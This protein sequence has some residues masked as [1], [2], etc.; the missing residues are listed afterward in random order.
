MRRA[1]SYA[2]FSDKQQGDGCSEERQVDAAKAYCERHGLTLDERSFVDRGVSAYTGANATKGELAE[3]LHLVREGRVP[4]GSAL[5]IENVD[6][7]SRLD[8][9]EATELFC[10]IVKAGVDIVTLAPEQWYKRDN[11]HRLDIW[12]P[13]QVAIALAREESRKKSERIRDA[14]ARKRGQL[15]DDKGKATGVRFTKR[16]PFWLEYDGDGGWTVIPEKAE[17]MVTMFEWAAA[18]LGMTKISARAYEAWPEGITGK[19]WQPNNIR[20]HLRSRAALG[21]FR[22]HVRVCRKAANGKGSW[23]GRKPAGDW[24]KGYYPAIVGEDLYYKAQAAIDGRRRAGGPA[25]RTPNLFNGILHDARDGCRMVITGGGAKNHRWLVSAGAITRRPGSEFITVPYPILER[26]VLGALCEL[27]ASD[28][29]GS[30]PAEDAV[31]VWSGRLAAVNHKIAQTQQRAAR[32]EDPTVFLDLLEEL[33]KERKEAVANRERAK[34]EATGGLGDSLGEC[35]GLR[36]LLEQASTD[37][38]RDDLRERIKGALRRLVDTVWLLVARHGVARLIAVQVNFRGGARRNYLIF[39][40]PDVTTVKGFVPGRVAVRSAHSTTDPVLFGLMEWDVREP[41]E[42]E[43][44][45]AWL[46]AYPRDMLN[47]VLTEEGAE[48]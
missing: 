7:L 48:L 33:A 29:T 42:A 47:R 2:R 13:L 3:F 12:I 5:I 27:K 24:I 36:S 40:R 34:A 39:Y 28:V 15:A 16:G 32:A 1:I 22:P 6:R 30:R 9:D 35:C 19:G 10:S 25:R 38:E 14:K 18:G 46:E 44:L 41:G 8:P 17:L 11:I 4:V 37:E 21:E 31:E 43:S 20:L 23:S 26:A 45:K